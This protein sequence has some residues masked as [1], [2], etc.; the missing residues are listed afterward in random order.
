M[1]TFSLQIY[2]ARHSDTIENVVSFIGEDTSGSF[3]ILADHARFMTILNVG[4]ARYCLEDGIW[5]YLAFPGAVLYFRDN[6]MFI[7]TRLYLQDDDYTNIS[8]LLLKQLDNEQ[9]EI[10]SIKESLRI[11]ENNLLKRMWEINRD[12]EIL[13]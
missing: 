3:G 1:K 10:A 4:L 13:Q 9:G 5:R 12:T 2:D 6:T 8:T 7:S 11:M